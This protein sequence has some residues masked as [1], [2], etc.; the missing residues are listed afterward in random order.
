MDSF[1]DKLE[2]ENEFRRK[3]EA[4]L[5]INEVD[6][7]IAPTIEMPIRIKYYYKNR[8]RG[9]AYLYELCKI[10]NYDG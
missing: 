9:G 4:A 1:E 6:R 5:K 7:F 3:I 2:I 8:A 10:G